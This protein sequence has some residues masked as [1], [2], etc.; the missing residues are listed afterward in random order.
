MAYNTVT[1]V[2]FEQPT[3][4]KMNLLG[5]NDAGFRDGTNISDN[6]ILARHIDWAST[7]ANGGIWWEELART[8]LTPAGDT[9]DCSSIPARKYLRVLL[10]LINTGGTINSSIR[11][12]NDSASNYARRL[13]TNNSADATSGS[14]NSLTVSSEGAFIQII[15]LDILNIASSEKLMQS[16]ALAGNTAGA[17]NVP[18]RDNGFSK[19]ANTSDSITRITSTNGGSGDYAVGSEIVVLGHN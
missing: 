9:L 13:S 1:F 15:I 17:G 12:N 19:W 4:A 6:V 18:Q 8:T 2:A 5:E 11:F 16:M 14:Q 7:G 3:A 10:S